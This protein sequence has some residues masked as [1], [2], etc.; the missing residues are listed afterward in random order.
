MNWKQFIKEIETKYPKLT[1]D[2]L[3]DFVEKFYG[4][5]SDLKTINAYWVTFV[6]KSIKSY[7]GVPGSVDRKKLSLQKRIN[8]FVKSK[9]FQWSWQLYHSKYYNDGD[10]PVCDEKGNLTGEIIKNLQQIG[11]SDIDDNTFRKIDH[12]HNITQIL[13]RSKFK[14]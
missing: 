10:Q 12:T 4:T 11:P 1:P 14:K 8:Y 9:N 5:K 3:Y 7:K 6:V 13:Q 2:K